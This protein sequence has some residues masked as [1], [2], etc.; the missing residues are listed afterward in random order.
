MLVN[1]QKINTIV[2]DFTVY[3]NKLYPVQ[4]DK[5]IKFFLNSF[6]NYIIFFSR[7]IPRIEQSEHVYDVCIQNQVNFET[8]K[9][10]LV[11]EKL[12]KDLPLSSG[13]K[14]RDYFRRIVGKYLFQSQIL[15]RF[16][17]KPRG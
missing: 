16:Y 17:D 9:F 10:L 1:N 4:D 5:L 6:K 14:V 3:L 12:E 13:A 15:K 2:K 11:A 8:D 7:I